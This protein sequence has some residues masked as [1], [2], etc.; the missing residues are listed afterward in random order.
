[1]RMPKFFAAGAIALAAFVVEPTM[2]SIAAYAATDVSQPGVPSIHKCAWV[3]NGRRW[4]YRWR[5]GFYNYRWGGRYFRT[6]FRC[7]RVR[8]GWCYR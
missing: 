3:H 8:G 7:A 2:E 4:R 6:R 1:M 5:G